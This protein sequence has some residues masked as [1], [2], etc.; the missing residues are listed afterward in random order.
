MYGAPENEVSNRAAGWRWDLEMPKCAR[1]NGNQTRHIL[2]SSSPAICWSTT[3]PVDLVNCCSCG[4]GEEHGDE[5]SNVQCSVGAGQLYRTLMVGK[6][7]HPIKSPNGPD[8]KTSMVSF[9]LGAN[10][11]SPIRLNNDTFLHK[12]FHGFL[13]DDR[14]SRHGRNIGRARPENPRA[15]SA[16]ARSKGRGRTDGTHRRRTATPC[17]PPHEVN[18]RKGERLSTIPGGGRAVWSEP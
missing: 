5:L 7:L 4:N 1:A 14:F 11:A 8:K 15:I 18:R 2:A 3:C 6:Q 16:R 12:I 13:Y 17:S 10:K 9:C